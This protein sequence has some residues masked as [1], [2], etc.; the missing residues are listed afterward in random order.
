MVAP[1][2][3]H[4]R[5]RHV[6]HAERGRHQPERHRAAHD[7]RADAGERREYHEPE[8]AGAESRSEVGLFLQTG[9]RPPSASRSVSTTSDQSPGV[10]N[11]GIQSKDRLILNLLGW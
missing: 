10:N 3:S 11:K 6:D 1:R 4:D 2:T 7:Q 8:D 9:E 5:P